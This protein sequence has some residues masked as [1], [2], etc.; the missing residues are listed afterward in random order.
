M[1][2]L[3]GAATVTATA[4][5]LFGYMLVWTICGVGALVAAVLLFFVPKLAFADPVGS[6]APE[7]ETAAEI[8]TQLI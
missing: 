7:S 4:A 6:D 3:T 5:S 2:L 1:V 8:P